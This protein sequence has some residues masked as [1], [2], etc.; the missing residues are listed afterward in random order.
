MHKSAL[1]I[2]AVIYFIYLVSALAILFSNNIFSN[3]E[4]K[5]PF[6][7]MHLQLK[8]KHVTGQSDIPGHKRTW[9]GLVLARG[10]QCRVIAFHLL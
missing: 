6:Q 9:D 7:Q 4:C 5:V 3:E 2:T 10:N 1:E 8:Q